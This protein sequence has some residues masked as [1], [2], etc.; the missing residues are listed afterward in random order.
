LHARGEDSGEQ[1]R[2]EVR[3]SDEPRFVQHD[4]LPDLKCG[5]FI[6]GF[7]VKTSKNSKAAIN[8][9]TP[10]VLV[11]LYQNAFS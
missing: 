11:P 10:N 9:R 3:S 8:R 1:C 4:G 5:D 6:A 2:N 7:G